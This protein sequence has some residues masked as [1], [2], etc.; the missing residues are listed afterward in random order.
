[1][2]KSSE[3]VVSPKRIDLQ[4]P[5]PHLANE[6]GEYPQ[7]YQSEASLPLIKKIALPVKLLRRD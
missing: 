2:Q 5:L 3:K 7:I 6:Q 4:L 1:M